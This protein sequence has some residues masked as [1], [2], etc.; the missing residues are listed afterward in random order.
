M[1]KLVCAWCGVAIDR[2]NCIEALDSATCYGMCPDCRAAL[3]S[4][5]HG[6][7]L[8][9]H[10]DTIP[11]PILLVDDSNAVV[12]M[13]TTARDMLGKELD[14]TETHLLGKVFDCIHSRNPEKCDRTIH[15]GGCAIRRSVTM[16]F[17]TGETQVSVP[18]TLNVT[19]PDDHS[20]AV[21]TV[22]TV[23]MGGLVLLR[24][25]AA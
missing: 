9:Q 4:Q 13:N 5:E 7:P 8:Q 25:E 20:E 16:T 1:T 18:A 19:S 11:V 15:C 22:S 12:T 10:L 3:E 2:P 23:K 17:H 14:G 24:I 21:F 6:A